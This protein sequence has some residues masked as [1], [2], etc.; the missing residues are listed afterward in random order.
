[1][2][3]IT[4]FNGNKQRYTTGL[5]RLIIQ[6]HINDRALEHIAENT[7]LHFKHTGMGYEAQPTSSNQIATLFMTYNYKTRY[8]NNASFDNTL[9]LR[10]DH[11]IGFDVGAICFDCCQYN[12]IVTNG[13]KKGDM[14]K[15]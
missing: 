4:R 6:G 10:S 2:E 1:M 5:P 13:L 11:H 14:L 3:T 9:M 15:C 8:F 12:H 7:G